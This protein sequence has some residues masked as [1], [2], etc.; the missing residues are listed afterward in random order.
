MGDTKAKEE[1]KRPHPMKHD[2]LTL[3][4]FC[5]GL[6]TIVNLN[7]CDNAKAVVL[8]CGHSLC[9]CCAARARRAATW[10][11]GSDTLRENSAGYKTVRVRCAECLELCRIGKESEM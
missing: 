1:L 8:D 10:E 6:H 7:P 3:H 11:L 4:E 5:K 2:F 9:L